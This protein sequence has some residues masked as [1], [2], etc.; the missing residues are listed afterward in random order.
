[1]LNFIRTVLIAFSLLVSHAQAGATDRYEEIYQE[2]IN[3][4]REDCKGGGTLYDKTVR[5]AQSLNPHQST[6]YAST[7][8]WRCMANEKEIVDIYYTLLHD[9]RVT[10]T[11]LRACVVTMPRPGASLHG[12]MLALHAC[13]QSKVK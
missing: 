4:S 10:L 7:D 8:T 5:Q 1:M 13:L 12:G 9:N 3:Y 6:E 11:N 2:L